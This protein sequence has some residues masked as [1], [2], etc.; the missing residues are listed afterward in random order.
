MF[1]VCSCFKKSHTSY[2]SLTVHT[3]DPIGEGTEVKIV[4]VVISVFLI[5]CK[6]KLNNINPKRVNTQYSKF[7][8][9]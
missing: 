8:I 5:L 7:L 1:F 2:D 6:W 4:G 9:G 3:V